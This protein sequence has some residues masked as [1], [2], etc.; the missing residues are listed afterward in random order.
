[1]LAGTFAPSPLY[2]THSTML[3]LAVSREDT[4]GQ[5]YYDDLPEPD[6]RVQ[7]VVDGGDAV[8]GCGEY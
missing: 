1:M 6:G 3:W 8:C 7:L 5:D 2:A 4:E